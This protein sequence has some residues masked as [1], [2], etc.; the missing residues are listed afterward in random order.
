MFRKQSL[1]RML[2]LTTLSTLLITL[3]LLIWGSGSQATE[4]QAD[5]YVSTTGGDDPSCGAVDS[6]CRTISYAV[7]NRAQAGA[8]VSVAAGVYTET[9][10]L[11][12]GVIIS[13]TGAGAT[14]VDGENLRGPLVT[15]VGSDVTDATVLRD[16]TIQRGITATFGGG[17]LITDGAAP[18]IENCAI[19][20]NTAGID[21]GGLYILEAF[22]TLKDTQIIS[23]AAGWEGGGL[24][25]FD[26]SPMLDNVQVLSNT[27]G[28]NGGGVS[29]YWYAAPTFT[30]GRVAA[31]TVI[32]DNGGGIA[33]GWYASPILSGTQIV[34][35]TAGWLGGGISI[36]EGSQAAL[37]NVQVLSN[38]AQSGGG[39]QVWS[40]STPTIVGGEVRGN[41]ATD[42]GG[43]FLV[44]GD[45]SSPLISGVVVRDNRATGEE[46]VSGGGGIYVTGGASPTIADVHV[47]SNTTDGSGGGCYIDFGSLAIISGTSVVGNV[48]ENGFGGGIA[49]DYESSAVMTH[50][51]VLSNTTSDDGGGVWVNQDSALTFSGGR[52]QGN[53][54]VSGSGGGLDITFQSTALISGVQ[55]LDNRDDWFAGGIYLSYI[56]TPTIHNCTIASNTH[57]G[58]RIETDVE[59]VTITQS[60]VRNNDSGGVYLNDGHLDLARTWVYGNG[61]CGVCAWDGDVALDNNVIADNAGDG[62]WTV[63]TTTGLLRHNTIADNGGI[64]VHVEY[65]T[66]LHLTNTIISG[67]DAG[68]TVTADSTATLHATLWYSNAVTNWGGAGVI[69][70]IDSITGNPAF[71]GG[72]D[73]HITAE[74]AARDAGINAGVMDDIDGQARPFG[75]DYDIGADEWHP[76]IA[77]D[78]VSVTGPPTTTVG[79]AATFSATVNPPTATLPIIH[80]WEAT[81]LSP[82]THT[83]YSISDTASF[84]WVLTG[85]KTITVTAVNCGDSDV[86]TRTITIE[87]L[88]GENYHIYLPLVVRDSK[89]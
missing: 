77:L 52:V 17:V 25:I 75:S 62:L 38:T 89:G 67:H 1:S 37:T 70:S 65:S 53:E 26:G 41:V 48:A 14:I 7:D 39:I 8:T 66:T 57:Y 59:A 34:S 40:A 47:L 64:G 85:S 86:A 76:C 2:M 12:A 87:A 51:D 16:L 32:T 35:N 36:D 60:I 20:E 13:G 23:N 54:A 82:V 27:A 80:T 33:I 22:P 30:G 84:T 9:F 19:R 11:K 15:A 79:S 6:P 43:G 18:A 28:W 46:Y 24:Y 3:T 50:V 69:T 72:G 42:S 29:M 74:S 56:V 10:S 45:G 63:S 88:P 78:E 31:N 68:I 81:G 83:V 55:V 71:V 4:V 49:I 61:G 44:V 73:Y 21:G 5:I 58:V